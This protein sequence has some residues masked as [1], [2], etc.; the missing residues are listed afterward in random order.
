MSD[1]QINIAI[2]E[3]CGWKQDKPMWEKSD[4]T[5][6]LNIP[7]YCNDLNVMREAE[8]T[9]TGPII[10]KY[11]DNCMAEVEHWPSHLLFLSARQRAEAFLQTILVA[12]TYKRRADDGQSASFHGQLCL[13]WCAYSE[14][15]ATARARSV[16]ACDDGI[17]T[18]M[19]AEGSARDFKI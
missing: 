13:L 12:G 5:Y 19:Q 1:K 8:K 2:A 15:D 14:T 18:R 16:Q 9:L 11:V 10:D 17:Q 4:G 6:T 7:D 3:Y